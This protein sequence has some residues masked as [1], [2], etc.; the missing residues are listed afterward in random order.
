MTT[1]GIMKTVRNMNAPGN[2]I[3]AGQGEPLPQHV[4]G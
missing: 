2:I 4:T 1:M 3:T